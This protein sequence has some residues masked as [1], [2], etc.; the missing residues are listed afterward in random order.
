[1]IEDEA[2]PARRSSADSRATWAAP[3]GCLAFGLTSHLV[4]FLWVSGKPLNSLAADYCRWDCAFY[5]SIAAHGYQPVIDRFGQA[6]WAFF[7]ALPAATALLHAVTGLDYTVAATLISILASFL[8]ARLAYALCRTPGQYLLM[9]A[10]LLIGPLSLYGSMPYSESLFVLFLVALQLLVKRGQFIGAGAAGAL[11]SASRA[12]G[13]FAGVALLVEA[14]ARHFS[15]GGRWRDLPT[16]FWRRP[17]VWLGLALV[18]FGL[19]ALILCQYDR[20]GDGL[21]FVHV[22]RLWYREL[23]DPVL[24]I[25]RGLRAGREQLG[26]ALAALAGLA[27]VAMLVRRRDFAMAVFCALCL[28]TP[29]LSGLE[30]ML[31]FTLALTPLWLLVAEFFGRTSR[32]TAIGLLLLVVTGFLTNVAWLSNA[33]FLV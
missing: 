16:F 12:V 8:A 4:A 32:R 22:Q 21:A 6:N 7:P 27:G 1:M 24:V 30:S 14:M 33:H 3:V 11:L 13:V 17:D 15:A 2:E 10:A 18:P 20:M 29:L 5:L 25:W 28:I 9:C 19:V 31:R 23:S 26:Q